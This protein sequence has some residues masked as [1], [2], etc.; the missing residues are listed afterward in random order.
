MKNIVFSGKLEFLNLAEL[1]QLIG[2]N[3]ST[4]ILEIRH[5]A[6]SALGVIYFLNGN[7]VDA[8]AG[9]ARG[10]PAV[11]DLFGWQSGEFFFSEESARRHKVISKNRMEIILDGLRMVD[12]G[13]TKILGVR[14]VDTHL[15]PLSVSH[16]KMLEVKGPLV[17]YIYVVDEE[18][19]L[20]GQIVA[21][22][23]KHGS[24]IW[25]VLEGM[26][27]IVKET[28]R[29]PEVILRLSEGAFVGSFASFLPGDHVRS[30]AAIAKGNVQLGVL[31]AP[32]LA[33]E[34]ASLSPTFR[35]IL[36]SL[37]KRLKEVTSR[38]LE[39][40]EKKLDGLEVPK[41][42]EP[43]SL[44]GERKDK[45][46][47]IKKGQLAIV[48]HTDY[49]HIQLAKLVKGDI[50]GYLSFV[51]TGHEPFSAAVYASSD[52]EVTEIDEEALQVEYAKQSNTL[53]NLLE[54]TTACT[55]ITTQL[56]M[57]AFLKAKS[58]TGKR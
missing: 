1:I 53:K 31:D 6:A 54:H 10:L 32:R 44:D 11:Y 3:G 41:G 30:A 22:E 47:F 58:G 49:G 36:I 37:D 26:V 29:G 34:F 50:F 7:P 4:G 52:L 57:D 55:T 46:F 2:N 40:R 39:I 18:S 25:V 28:K 16:D 23:G 21:A 42:L 14:S 45:L 8:H 43:F 15:S 19:F 17:D 56:V 38:L 33:G 27:D 13:K 20:D 24:W 12:D 9:K 48:R 5:S 35:R 51:Q